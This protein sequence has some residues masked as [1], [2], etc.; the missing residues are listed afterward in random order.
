MI[1]FLKWC[2]KN[3]TEFIEWYISVG[4]SE[5]WSDPKA[6]NERLNDERYAARGVRS[7]YVCNMRSE[8]KRRSRKSNKRS[9]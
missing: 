6:S 8:K 4:H 1:D 9:K 7:K 2:E 3:E 5:D